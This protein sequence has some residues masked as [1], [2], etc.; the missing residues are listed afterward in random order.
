MTNTKK[1]SITL[2]SEVADALTHVATELSIA[3]SSLINQMLRNSVIEISKILP[4]A[5]GKSSKSD[6]RRLRG[7]SKELVQ[8][9]VDLAQDNLRKR[10]N[11]G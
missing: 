10:D 8:R 6:L 4:K 9:R 7:K 5:A 2:E 1:L 3:K 11:A